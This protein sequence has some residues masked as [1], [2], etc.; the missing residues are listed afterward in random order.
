[1]RMCLKEVRNRA[2]RVAQVLEQLP[3]VSTRPSVQIPEP[4][5]RNQN[6]QVY[7]VINE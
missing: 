7:Q 3:N 1:M 6:I 5:K 4:Q 2:S